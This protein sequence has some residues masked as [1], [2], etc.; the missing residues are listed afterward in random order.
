MIHLLLSAAGGSV[1]GAL[2]WPRLK[3]LYSNAQQ[4]GE[5]VK[6]KAEDL[7]KKL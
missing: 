2:I 1:I 7:A 6:Q 4:F 3:A 5:G